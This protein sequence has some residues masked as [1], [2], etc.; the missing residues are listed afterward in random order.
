MRGYP[1][2]HW[3]TNLQAS[4]TRI[5]LIGARQLL[6]RRRFNPHFVAKPNHT[7][8]L[9]DQNHFVIRTREQ[10]YRMEAGRL[11]WISPGVEFEMDDN[12]PQH[13]ARFYGVGFSVKRAGRMI[14]APAPILIVD[15][16]RLAPLLTLLAEQNIEPAPYG[17]ET[18]RPILLTLTWLVRGEIEKPNR[19]ATSGGLSA[20]ERLRL[21][22][23]VRERLPHRIEPHHLALELQ[24]APAYFSRLFKRTYGLAPKSWLLQQRLQAAAEWLL[25]SNDTISEVADRFEFSDVYNFSQ[26]FKLFHG[27]SPK[28]YREKQRLLLLD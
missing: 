2:K 14:P 27:L 28:H 3:L 18:L 21:E 12:H 15:C 5:E 25:E 22:R 20:P 10:E 17:A 16:H 26:Q 11:A 7:L 24:R 23:F 8:F 9:V 1:W 13:P 4:N 6:L 19:E